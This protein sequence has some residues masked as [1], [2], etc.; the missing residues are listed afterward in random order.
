M[1]VIIQR[2]KSASVTIDEKIYNEIGYGMLILVGFTEGDSTN[3]IDY[4]VKKIVNLRIFGDE[5]G[6]MN[7]SILDIKGSILSIS[8]FTLYADASK[9]NRPSFTKVADK[10][11]AS[12]LYGIFNEKLNEFITTKSGIFGSSMQIELINDGPVTIIFDS[13]T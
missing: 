5:K 4:L 7:E 6:L 1:R 12:N 13:N 8:Q 11:E 3:D 2:V 9:G 10:D